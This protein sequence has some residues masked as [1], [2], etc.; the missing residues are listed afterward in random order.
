MHWRAYAKLCLTL[1]GTRRVVGVPERAEWA[2]QKVAWVIDRKVSER[3]ALDLEQNQAAYWAQSERQAVKYSKDSASDLG[4]LTLNHLQWFAPFS[5][6]IRYIFLRWCP[7][8]FGRPPW[9][10]TAWA[11]APTSVCQVR[12]TSERCGASM[13]TCPY[14]ST[15]QYWL[16]D[17]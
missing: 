7:D 10:E 4:S 2:K 13:N 5:D 1:M 15:K 9:L 6:L 3:V 8:P 14:F 16:S 17:W 11:Q 12:Q